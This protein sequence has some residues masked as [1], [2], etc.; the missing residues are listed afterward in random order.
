MTEQ[1]HPPSDPE[2]ERARAFASVVEQYLPEDKEFILDMDEEEALG[3]VYG[4]LLEMGEDPDVV[5][6]EF[7]VTEENEDEV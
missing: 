6:R 7:G 5:L 1:Y 3:Y 4:M 2:L